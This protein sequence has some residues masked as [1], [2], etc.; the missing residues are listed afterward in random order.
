M[1]T[2]VSFGGADSSGETVSDVAYARIRADILFGHLA[3]GERLRLDASSRRYGASVSTMREL[4]NRLASEGLVLAEGQRGFQVAPVSP[5]EFRE[6]GALR[7]LL[8][9]HA[10]TQ[11]FASG[12]LDWEARVVAAHH[13]L[14]VTEGRMIEGA[15]ADP[16]SWKQC[17]REFHQALISACGSNVLMA[18]HSSVYDKY[19]RY[20]MIAIVFRGEAAAREHGI[21]LDCALTRDAHRANA[22]LKTHIESC[23]DHALSGDPPGWAASPGRIAETGASLPKQT[24]PARPRRQNAKPRMARGRGSESLP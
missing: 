15:G 17:D 20:Q 16:V 18:A 11:S 7:L 8:E 19:L 10:L 22:T 4:L 6:V 13:K 9:T 3:P 23:L 1:G 14:S 12:D 24:R 5:S 2:L 21:L